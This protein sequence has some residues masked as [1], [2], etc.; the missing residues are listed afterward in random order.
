MA[1]EEVGGMVGAHADTRGEELLL[2]IP[3]VTADEGDNFVDD[4][5]V[6]V[7]VAAGAVGGMRIPVRPGLP[8]QAV[9]REDLDLA[10]FDERGQHADHP[11]IFELVEAA[12]LRRKDQHRLSKIAIDFQFHVVS[13]AGTEPFVIFDL[14]AFLFYA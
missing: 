10:R 14:H 4:I 5:A 1:K 7:L 9:D 3:A 12:G 6:I 2:R 11:K 8:V 13:Q